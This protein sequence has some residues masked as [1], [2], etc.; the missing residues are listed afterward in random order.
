VLGGWRGRNDPKGACVRLLGG[1]AV[2]V[3]LYSGRMSTAGWKCM[4]VRARG[5][6]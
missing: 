6:T 5:L 3:V 4:C 2:L 1:R